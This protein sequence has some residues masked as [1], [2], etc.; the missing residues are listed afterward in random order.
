M[1]EE[2]GGGCEGG[3]EGMRGR[4]QGLGESLGANVFRGDIQK[5]NAQIF[6]HN[7]SDSC[8]GCSEAL[9]F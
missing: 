6:E 1:R 3:R 5:H 2:G 9:G 7:L 4:M 8:C